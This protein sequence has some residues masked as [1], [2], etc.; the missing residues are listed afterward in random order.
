MTLTAPGRSLEQRTAALL[1]ANDI[2]TR[3]S[4]LKRDIKAGNVRASDIVMNPPVWAETMRVPVLLVA[5]PLLGSTKTK[6]LLERHLISPATTLG[7]LSGRQRGALVAR[8]T[9]W[10]AKPRSA[11][12][13]HQQP[14]AQVLQALGNANARRLERAVLRAEVTSLSQIAARERVAELLVDPPQ[15]LLSESIIDLLQWPHRD[16]ARFASRVMFRVGVSLQRRVGEITVRQR[17]VFA[18][19]LHPDGWLRRLGEAA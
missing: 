12:R 5:V 16:G 18:D 11:F 4:Q 6:K 17:G 8:L 15:C 9:V 2:R 7:G 19:E 3:R 1:K 10:E 13:P 14:N